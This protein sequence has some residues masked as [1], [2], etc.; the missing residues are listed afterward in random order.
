MTVLSLA[1][2]ESRLTH[3]SNVL[4]VTLVTHCD[5]FDGETLFA[6][7]TSNHARYAHLSGPPQ[8]F[9]PRVDRTAAASGMGSQPVAPSVQSSGGWLNRSL[10]AASVAWRSH[11]GGSH[12]AAI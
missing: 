4:R 5:P 3:L 7:A 6:V 12:T 10:A 2:S 8:S 1:V 9:L 11:A